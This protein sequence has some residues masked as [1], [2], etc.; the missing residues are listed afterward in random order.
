LPSALRLKS[1]FQTTNTQTYL[2]T[3][4]VQFTLPLAQIMFHLQLHCLIHAAQQK[5]LSQ[6]FSKTSIHLLAT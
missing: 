6:L 3:T 4:I 2:L 5:L 1:H